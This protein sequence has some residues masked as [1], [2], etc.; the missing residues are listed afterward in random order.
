MQLVQVLM[1]QLNKL[2]CKHLFE[3]NYHQN[4]YIKNTRKYSFLFFHSINLPILAD[5]NLFPIRESSPT[6]LATSLTDA[7]VAS[8]TAEIVLILEIRCAKNALATYRYQ[9]FFNQI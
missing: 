7:P 6:A 3:N 1:I 4:L 9:I 2:N 5:K 8:Q